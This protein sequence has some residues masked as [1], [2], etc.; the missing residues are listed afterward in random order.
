MLDPRAAGQPSVTRLLTVRNSAWAPHQIGLERGLGDQTAIEKPAQPIGVGARRV[1]P[2]LGQG[3]R[4]DP[5]SF[6]NRNRGGMGQPAGIAEVSK[7]LLRP[8]A[9]FG[10]CRPVVGDLAFEMVGGHSGRAVAMGVQLD[11]QAAPIGRA[12][13]GRA[14]QMKLAALPP[15]IRAHAKPGGAR[16][17]RLLALRQRG[18]FHDL[19]DD[20]EALARRP[21]GAS[22]D[23]IDNHIDH[24]YLMV[25]VPRR[26][27]D[28]R[29]QGQSFQDR[30][31]MA[32]GRAPAVIDGD[33]HRVVR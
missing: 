14:H 22:Q 29:R 19:G 10:Q 20:R 2:A 25:G 18:Q 31:H 1:D 32:I 28:G 24:R 15:F 33:H 6:E 27:I 11:V 26:H 30:Q 5:G 13:L 9:R 8:A 23:V 12:D 3:R 4:A 7:A 17:Q 16:A 21:A